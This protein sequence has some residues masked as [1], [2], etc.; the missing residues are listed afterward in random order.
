VTG[1]KSGSCGSKLKAIS[2]RGPDREYRRDSICPFGHH[3][4][5]APDKRRPMQS[6]TRWLAHTP[7]TEPDALTSS[8]TRLPPDVA[9]LNRLVQGLLIHCDALW[10]YGENPGAFGPISRTTLPVKQ[11]LANLLNRDGR[12]LDEA[13]TPTQREVG[14]CRDFALMVCA[15]LRSMGTAARLRCGFASY[16]A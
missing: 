1:V 10:R 4:P 15:F 16:F 11:R 8:F 6:P 3:A 9:S 14:T 5:T 13:R 7:M 2:D 12:A